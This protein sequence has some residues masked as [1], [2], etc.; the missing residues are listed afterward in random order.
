MEDG[1][2]FYTPVPGYADLRQA[3]VSKLSSDNGLNYSADQIV[4]STGAKQSIANLVI[5][6]VNPGDE[7]IIPAPYWVSYSEIV[8]LVEGECVFV[9]AGVE[10]DRS[11]E[12]TSE[13]Q[14]L[15][16]ISYAVFC[17]KKKKI[18]EKK[19]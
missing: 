13:L 18:N 6:L 1:F 8:K 16:R 7:V 12:H 11:E 3:I 5:S 19:H 10:N 14:S 9:E 15:M 17:L 2:T 4:V